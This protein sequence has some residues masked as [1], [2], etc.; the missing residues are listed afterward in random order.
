MEME[1]PEGL[2]HFHF[3]FHFHHLFSRSPQHTSAHRFHPDPTPA[4]TTIA[5]RLRVRIPTLQL[6]GNL[7]LRAEALLVLGA[8]CLGLGAC[9]APKEGPEEHARVGR[10]I[11]PIVHGTAS[12][13]DQDSVVA[14]ARFENGTRV[15]L[16]T[17][18]LVAANLAL[19]A[20]HCVTASD[21][22]A[23]CGAD[24]S[25]VVGAMFHGDRAANTLA[26]YATK[27]GA[28]PDTTVEAGAT[29]HGKALV[30]DDATTLCNHDLAFVILDKSLTAPIAPVRI[31]A[32]AMTDVLTA[33]GFGITEVGS[34]PT[35]RMQRGGLALVGAGPM[36][37][38]DDARYGIGNAEFLV[39]ESACSGDSGS[40]ALA[41]SGAVVGVA[42]RAGNGQPRDPANAASNCLGATA[43][44]VYAQLGANPALALRAFEEAGATPWLEGQPDP[45]SV[46]PAGSSSGVTAGRAGGAAGSS[47]GARAPAPAAP[48]GDDALAPTGDRGGDPSAASGCSAAGEPTHGAV[49]DALGIAF[50]ILLVLKFRSAHRRR[51]YGASNP[52]TTAP[53]SKGRI[54]YVDLGMRESFASLPDD[55]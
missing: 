35:L 34:L 9:G 27:N 1:M 44:A 6:R 25:P 3:H 38:P 32:P 47:G 8:A 37:Y 26:V 55:R 5:P 4:G 20:R 22:A 24:G 49:E 48:A 46:E 19:T 21:A 10:A 54:P 42:S 31:A 45:R 40:P 14:L 50:L 43:H 53:D 23:A 7:T 33:V 18:T 16:C 11:Q 30:V 41:A 29:A 15:G 2:R 51:E 36:A 13:T 17:A 39:G 28:A 52:A 12:G